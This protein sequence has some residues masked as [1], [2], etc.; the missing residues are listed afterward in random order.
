MTTGVSTISCKSIGVCSKTMTIGVLRLGE[1][2]H[3][4]KNCYSNFYFFYC[5]RIAGTETEI[6]GSK[7]V[8][9]QEK[10]DSTTLRWRTW[11]ELCAPQLSQAL[12]SQSAPVYYQLEPLMC[13]IQLQVLVKDINNKANLLV[14]NV[15]STDSAM[16]P[17][18]FRPLLNNIY[19][20]VRPYAAAKT[21]IWNLSTALVSCHV[22]QM[23]YVKQNAV[24]LQAE[25]NKFQQMNSMLF[26]LKPTVLQQWHT[27][28]LS[29][30]SA[31][32][33]IK[34]GVNQQDKQ[35]ARY[36]L[37]SC[38]MQFRVNVVR[39]QE[40]HIITFIILGILLMLWPPCD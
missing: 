12:L 39:T 28:T 35:F 40:L 15:S 18:D 3:S 34:L 31:V 10:L 17:T 6:N 33:P 38:S 8:L 14:F 1:L 27:N 26:K 4:F 5:V 7:W 30:N 19:N 2:F 29:W 22:F 24:W 16:K 36:P 11:T 25:L 37:S 13:E 23:H 32:S 9:S 21:Q 20:I